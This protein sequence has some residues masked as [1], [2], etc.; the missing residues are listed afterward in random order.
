[1][2]THYTTKYTYQAI[3]ALILA[4]LFIIP[5]SANIQNEQHKELRHTPL[6]GGGAT[7]YVDGKNTAG[8]W[9][10][11]LEHPYQFI[12]DGITYAAATDTVYVFSGTYHE[13]VTVL[14]SIDL[15]GENKD[16]T[17]IDANH[18]GSA[19]RITAEGV[20]MSGFTITHSGSNPNDAGIMVHS[21]L[22]TIYENNIQKNN[23]GLYILAGDNTVYHN[24]ILQNT[25]QA[26]DTIASSAWDAGYPTGGNYWS[27][28]TGTDT[29][30]D[31][32]GEIPYPTGNSSS[33]RYPLI[34]PYG[35]IIN[36]DTSEIFLTIQGAIND[37]ETIDGH[38]IFVKNGDYWEHVTIH[39]SLL[40]KGEDRHETIIDGRT[41]GD[42]VSICAYD[43]A[44]QGF[45]IQHSGLETQNAGIIINGHNCSLSNTIIFDN[46]NGVILKQSARD[47]WIY[48]NEI[49]DNQWNGMSIKSGCKN[50]LIVE[51]TI[52]DNLYAGLGISDASYN[53]IYHN[54]FKTNHNQAY[55]NA[56][57][58]WDNGYPSG[59]N[60]WS[61][62]TG[63][64]A[65]A[66][67]IGDTPYAIPDGI[68]TDRYPLMAP[69]TTQ[70][71]IPPSV[72]IM[73]P[74]NG[75]YLFN[76]RMLPRLFR[77]HT[78]IIGK[79]TITVDATDAQ[80]GMQ[81]VEFYIDNAMQPEFN[82]SIFP[83][84]WTWAHGSLLKH[85]H[86][87]VIM[88]YDNAGNVKTVTLDVKRYF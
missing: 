70:D 43:V 51:N 14:V 60:Y 25:Y 3:F 56:N 84:S 42:V 50:A 12:M 7:I 72:T 44:L 78:I 36:Q 21:Q 18:S 82:D 54:T 35:S 53:Y 62:Y 64:D 29:T 87:L 28:Y 77:Q 65:N 79:V 19:V 49:T 73:S 88:A 45:L 41:T 34:H 32:I 22:N 23:F 39:K 17:I 46:F 67:G 4:G 76:H 38:T 8:P 55:D 69:Y 74:T 86:T 24:N 83:Y 30:E 2:N 71:L 26:F 9:D 75:L 33:D 10:G 16:T 31:G 80:S 5:A 20:M 40:L 15:I 6:D 37:A 27:D 63:V 81:K 13:Q 11:S 58:I 85:K 68:S 59:G 66:D 52:S 47:A 1:M 48:Q 57:N 61:D